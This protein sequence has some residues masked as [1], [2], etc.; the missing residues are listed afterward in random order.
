MATVTVLSACGGSDEGNNEVPKSSAN[1]AAENTAIA[2]DLQ[3]SFG[4]LP[5]VT[6]AEVNY[7]DNLTS[8]GSMA[9]RMQ[10][11]VGTDLA[12]LF[13]TV[14]ELIWLSELDPL[15]TIALSAGDGGNPPVADNRTLTPSRDAD[16][17][18]LEELY[19]PRPG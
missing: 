12:P 11:A 8:P 1:S 14:T 19:G 7:Q 2:S 15:N 3:E 18:E 10:V 4:K 16:H 6:S 13:D 9:V 17:A 5:G